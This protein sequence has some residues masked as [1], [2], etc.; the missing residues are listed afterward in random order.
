MTSRDQFEAW[1]TAD[2][3]RENRVIRIVR[4]RDWYAGRDKHF[5][6]GSWAAWQASSNAPISGG[7]L[8]YAVLLE[9]RRALKTENEMLKR[10]NKKAFANGR[11]SGLDDASK[12]CYQLALAQYRP[13][14][15]RYTMFI[16]KAH[17][18]LGDVLCAACNQIADLPDGPL[19]RHRERQEQKAAKAKE[20]LS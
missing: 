2:A 9:D 7:D 4:E 15:S 13:E 6:N 14:G 8:S 16:P 10:D 11:N 1:I 19:Q 3:A 12:L 18:A 17:K 20:S 5:L